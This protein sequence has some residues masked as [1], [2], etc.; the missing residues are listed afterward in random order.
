MGR[1][2]GEPL[3]T[4][5]IGCPAELVVSIVVVCLGAAF[6]AFEA[7][8]HVPFAHHRRHVNGLVL[9][10]GNHPGASMY[11][12]SKALL[13]KLIH[14]ILMIAQLLRGVEE[15]EAAALPLVGD[16]DLLLVVVG[17]A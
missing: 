8:E 7:Y 12:F 15:L 14:L 4:L 17:L 3:R 1:G 5:A 2:T 10:D 9:V 13:V 16:V 6:R 11:V